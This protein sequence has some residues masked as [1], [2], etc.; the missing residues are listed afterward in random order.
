LFKK[1]KKKVMDECELECVREAASVPNFFTVTFGAF[2]AQIHHYLIVNGNSQSVTNLDDNAVGKAFVVGTT[3]QLLGYTYQKSN[4]S[5]QQMHLMTNDEVNRL[6]MD[7]RVGFVPIDSTVIFDANEK[8]RLFVPGGQ[9]A[10]GRCLVTLYF[11]GLN[12]EG[13]GTAFERW[14]PFLGQPAL[15]STSPF[16]ILTFAGANVKTDRTYWKFN[17]N[18]NG[19]VDTNAN[20]LGVSCIIGSTILVHRMTWDKSSTST[21]GVAV[22][23]SSRVGGGW[24][25]FQMQGSSGFRNFSPPLPMHVGDVFQVQYRA[26]DAAPPGTSILSFYCTPL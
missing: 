2:N 20:G 15:E 1:S 8:F 26:V 3:M 18:V 14:S 16:S 22:Q 9:P 19:P 17:G 24:L 6:Q 4:D 23:R 12:T 7:G 5:T 10:P 11:C 25:L 21:N 13:S